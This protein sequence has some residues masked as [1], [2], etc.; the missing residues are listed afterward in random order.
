MPN[1]SLPYMAFYYQHMMVAEALGRRYSLKM[2]FLK[3]PE[4]H[5]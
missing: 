2:P 1:I 3:M 5:R 4:V